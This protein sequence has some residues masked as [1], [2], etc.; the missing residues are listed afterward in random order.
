MTTKTTKIEKVAKGQHYET[1]D[2]NLVVVTNGRL[3][4]EGELGNSFEGKAVTLNAKT[5]KLQTAKKADRFYI[6]ELVRKLSKAELAEWL[7]VEK[8]EAEALADGESNPPTKKTTKPKAATKKKDT[9]KLSQLDAAIQ[10]L[11][12]NGE[13]MRC[14][15][16]VEAMLAKGIWSTN[17]A[18]P[19]ATLY[20]AILREINN[21]G[22]EARF[23]KTARGHFALN[24]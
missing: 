1:K 20:S 5:G 13:P 4:D 17:G 22:D 18:T 7:D 6:D 10:V 16:M 19:A 15:D 9:A 3:K 23:K 11:T 14:K 8:R 12:E 21:K 24:Q 2:H